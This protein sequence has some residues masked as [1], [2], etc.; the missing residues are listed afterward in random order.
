MFGDWSVDVPDNIKPQTVFHFGLRDVVIRDDKKDD[1]EKRMAL[2]LKWAIVDDGNP[3]HEEYFEMTPKD[4]WISFWNDLKKEDHDAFDDNTKK[5]YKIS[6]MN[7]KA[8]ARAFGYT[9]E[10]IK[11]LSPYD[12][13]DKMGIVVA[14]KAY[15]NGN[16]EDV[17]DTKSF[18][19]LETIV[20]S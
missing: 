4:T 17:L 2:I 20:E 11:S 3:D 18:A 16:G 7:F 5:T 10:E 12:F 8:I 19:S 1:D 14:A 13:K 15:R 9:E 6:K